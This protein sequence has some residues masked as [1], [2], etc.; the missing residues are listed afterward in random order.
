MKDEMRKRRMVDIEADLARN[1]LEKF[2]QSLERKKKESL[3]KPG[4]RV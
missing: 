4:G 3:L 1:E 2:E